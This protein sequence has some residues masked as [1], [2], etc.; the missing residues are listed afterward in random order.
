MPL[1][2]E[3]TIV[4]LKE[5]KKKEKQWEFGNYVNHATN[6]AS[7]SESSPKEQLENI[8]Y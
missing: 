1:I 3:V 4:C 2:L 7:Q 5:E 8:S 6:F